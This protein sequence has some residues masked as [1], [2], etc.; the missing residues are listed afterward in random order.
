MPVLPPPFVSFMDSIGVNISITMLPSFV[1]LRESS[2]LLRNLTDMTL[3]KAAGQVAR[4]HH[5][6]WTRFRPEQVVVVSDADLYP[7]HSHL[8]FRE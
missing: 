8:F 2:P 6:N 1:E 4:A 7:T 5:T 3:V